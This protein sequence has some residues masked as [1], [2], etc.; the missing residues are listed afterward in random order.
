VVAGVEILGR[1]CQWCSTS[2]D[3]PHRPVSGTRGDHGVLVVVPPALF[4]QMALAVGEHFTVAARKPK[5]AA[6]VDETH[7]VD[8]FMRQG[9]YRARR[10]TDFIG[11]RWCRLGR[12]GARQH[13]PADD[14]DE[15]AQRDECQPASTHLRASLPGLLNYTPGPGRQR[16]RD[17]TRE[18]R[19][20]IERLSSSVSAHDT[21]WGQDA[22]TRLQ[23]GAGGVVQLSS[24]MSVTP[25]SSIWSVAR[26]NSVSDIT[27]LSPLRSCESMDL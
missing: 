25:I 7:G 21:G 3:A 10:L 4:R 27:L 24:V 8:H 13:P 5:R 23:R 26:T 1:I 22:L 11:C 16:D 2:D 14:D 12:V 19:T 9:G 18:M 17:M 6:C 20:Y 15:C